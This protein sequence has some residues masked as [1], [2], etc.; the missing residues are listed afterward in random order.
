MTGDIEV[1]G[2]TIK[3]VCFTNS[4]KTEAKHPDWRIM[5]SEPR[6]ESSGQQ[7]PR[8]NQAELNNLSYDDA[9]IH[10]GNSEEINPEDIP[11]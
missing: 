6:Q 4:Y 3:I 2:Q 5:K 8:D 7:Q 10:V 9:P 11:F 1:N